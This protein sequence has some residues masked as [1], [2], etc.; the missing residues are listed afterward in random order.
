MAFKRLVEIRVG[1]T[2]HAVVISDLHCSFDVKRAK[3]LA[4]NSAKFKIY[5]AS[6]ETINEMLSENNSIEL[7]A[8]YEDEGTALLF[9]GSIEQSYTK[10]DKDG[11]RIT[12]IE[13]KTI[14]GSFEDVSQTAISLSYS[15]NG[16]IQDALKDVCDAMGLSLYGT[17]LL[18]D[19]KF[20]NGFVFSGMS[21]D[22]LKRIE[23]TVKEHNLILFT[24][25]GTLNVQEENVD[26][27]DTV[28]VALLTFDSGLLD[29]KK[30][31][32]KKKKKEIA[33]DE[34]S[35]VSNKTIITS[36]LNGKIVVG[37]AVKLETVDLN[38]LILVDTLNHKGDNFGKEPFITKCEGKLL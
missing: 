8:G 29:Y 35:D 25:N 26:P 34:G 5:N 12:Y 17:N 36:L 4:D 18:A 30:K 24:D 1:T 11:S 9:I 21:K 19:K 20:K 16:R 14:S 22:A 28:E 7:E 10:F 27:N 13:A 23:D 15:K 37:R 31:T 32:K 33:E 3:D 6:K 2:D 38:E